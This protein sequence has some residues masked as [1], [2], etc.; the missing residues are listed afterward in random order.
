MNNNIELI[1]DF[2]KFR[3]RSIQSKDLSDVEMFQYV[4]LLNKLV[5]IVYDRSLLWLKN[6]KVVD[7][8][9]H[10]MFAIASVVKSD[11]DN[12]EYYYESLLP[13]GFVIA[14]VEKYNFAAAKLA[15]LTA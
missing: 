4:D 14:W 3:G 2:G 13:A 8:E 7:A 1:S 5:N 6:V 12:S 15:A 10:T 9:F 11:F